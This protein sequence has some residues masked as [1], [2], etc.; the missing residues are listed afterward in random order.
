V[1]LPQVDHETHLFE[2]FRNARP[3]FDQ[4]MRFYRGPEVRCA[5]PDGPPIVRRVVTP[6][7]LRRELGRL[8]HQ[9][10]NEGRL[11]LSD[12]VVLTPRAVESSA[13]RGKVGTFHLTPTPQAHGDVKLSTIHR[14]KGLEAMAVIVCEVDGEVG[15][16]SRALLYVACS[17]ARSFLAVLT[18]R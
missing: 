17:R 3:I 14:F 7:E 6:G 5:G 9:V 2:N 11:S 10:I 4:V 12:V 13:V 8:L 18:T 15:R 16:D 1:G